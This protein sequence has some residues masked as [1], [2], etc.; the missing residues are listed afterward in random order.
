M[1][2]SCMKQPTIK[3]VSGR[4]GKYLLGVGGFE[5]LGGFVDGEITHLVIHKAKF[6]GRLTETH[7]LFILNI[8]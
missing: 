4:G 2:S 8:I 6:N 1:T 7:F 5:G 3:G